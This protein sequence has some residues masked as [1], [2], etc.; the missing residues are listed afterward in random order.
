MKTLTPSIPVSK[1]ND[2]KLDRHLSASTD[3]ARLSIADYLERGA[4]LIT[5]KAVTELRRLRPQLY[6][7]I[8]QVDDSDRLRLRLRI[9]TQYFEEGA[10]SSGADNSAYRETVFALLYF[11]KGFDRI[12]DSIPEIGLLDDALIVQVV[13][14][15]Q[16]AALRAHWLQYGRTWPGEL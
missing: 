5:P 2:D 7:K 11:L 8:E 4:A 3:E 16:A 1:Y 15:Q 14:Q 12:P 10:L 6:K 9:L 13:L